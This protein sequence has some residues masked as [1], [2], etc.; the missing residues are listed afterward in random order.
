[1]VEGVQ[2]GPVLVGTF[3]TTRQPPHPGSYPDPSPGTHQC[4]GRHRVDGRA[5]PRAPDNV[6]APAGTNAGESPG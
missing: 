5:A 1:M 2:Q 3:F 4:P 6:P